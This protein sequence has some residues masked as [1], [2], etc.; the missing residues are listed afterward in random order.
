MPTQTLSCNSDLA[1]VH[2]LTLCTCTH[3]RQ[4]FAPPSLLPTTSQVSRSSDKKAQTST[5]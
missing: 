5:L 1:F 3:S 4:R 2:T